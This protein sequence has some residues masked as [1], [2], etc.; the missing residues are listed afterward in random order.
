MLKN[1]TTIVSKHDKPLEIIVNVVSYFHFSTNYNNYNQIIIISLNFSQ[2]NIYSLI[3]LFS[4]PD[5]NI[6]NLHK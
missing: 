2:F 1:I 4:D 5:T 6:I 3:V